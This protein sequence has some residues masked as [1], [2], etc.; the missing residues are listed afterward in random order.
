VVAASEDHRSVDTFGWRPSGQDNVPSRGT[1]RC[2]QGA[3]PKEVYAAQ[4]L[5]YTTN[6]QQSLIGPEACSGAHFIASAAE[7]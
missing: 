5:A 7:A 6:M 4:L 1:R 2:R 3:L